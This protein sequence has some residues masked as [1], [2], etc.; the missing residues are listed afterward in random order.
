MHRPRALRAGISGIVLTLLAGALVTSAPSDAAGNPATPGNY[1]GLGFDQCDAPSQNAMDVWKEKSP[2]SAVGIYISGNSRGCRTQKNLTTTWVQKQLA[3]GWHLMPI[4][5]G[6]QAS[7]NPYFPRYDNDPKI[8]ASSSYTYAAARA[9]GK[10]EAAKAVTVAKSLG[11]VPGSTLFYD[12]EAWDTTKSTACNMSA[13]WFLSSWSNELHRLRYLSGVYSS[14]ASGI[15]VLDNA[16]Q[17][18]P[19]RYVG[20]DVIWLA[21]WNGV[22]TTSATNYIPN[23][24]WASHQRIKQFRG[25]KK[26]TYGGVT[27]NIDRNYLDVRS[28]AVPPHVAEPANPPGPQDTSRCTSTSI[29]RPAYRRTSATENRALVLPLQCLLTQRHLYT[30]NVTGTWNAATLKALQAFQRSQGR[31]ATTAASRNDWVAL[32]T[33]GS[34]TRTL[35]VKATGSDVIRIQRAMNAATSRRLKVTGVFNAATGNA[36]AAYRKKLRMTKQPVVTAA[37]WRALHRGRW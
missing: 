33:L 3:N 29:S 36:V 37:V 15:K 12:I 1:T 23:T 8:K 5:L 14:V 32:L 20:P 31:H 6:P 22:A 34:S 19:A 18:P 28:R 26:E 7:C 24:G 4:T 13:I 30:A 35:R 11:I 9:Q 16:R 2:F 21:R 27:I 17:D 25:G 10:A